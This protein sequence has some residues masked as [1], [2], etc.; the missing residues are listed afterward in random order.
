MT[1]G[2]RVPRHPPSR[3]RG[4]IRFQ[5][6]L[7]TAGVIIGLGIVGIWMSVEVSSRPQFCGSCHIMEPYYES[8][9]GSRHGMV[10]CVECHIPPGVT[11]EFRKKYEALSM[12]ASY[13]TGTYGTNPWTE[14][15]D[16]A[17]LRC[18][19]RRLLT[20]G[21]L[22][23]DVLFDHSAHL[24]GMRRGKTLR[25]TSCHSQIV[26]GSHIA[27]TTSTCVLCHF[28][29]QTSGTGTARCTLC[30]HVPDK[31]IQHESLTFNHADVG[32]LGMDCT[33]CHARPEG[34]DGAVP[35]ERCVT[36]HNEPARLQKYEETE[37]LHR[38]H[39]S[40]HKVDCMDCHLEIQHVGPPRIEQAT[41]ACSICHM[42]GHSPQANLYAGIGGKGVDPMP[43]AMFLAGVRCEGCHLEIPGQTTDTRRASEISC[44]SCHGP[45]YR[46]IF[47]AWKEGVADRTEGLQL[48]MSQTVAALGRS[49][50][51]A[52]ADARF[53]LN[54]VAE[55]RGVHNV[56]YAQALLS[57]SHRDMNVARS[58]RGLPPLSP[59]WGEI[60]QESDCLGCHFGIETSRGSIFGRPFQHA[61]HV[62]DAGL[63]CSSCHRPHEERREDE[64]VRFGAAGCESCHHR[65]VAADCLACHGGIRERT[66]ES[67]LG[68]F[69]H[70]LHLDELELECAD[71][72]EL[73]GDE[74]V[75]LIEETCVNC[76]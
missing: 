59:P 30:H 62:V 41:A 35:R 11:A 68:D 70:I 53:N 31:V 28:K 24:S 40:E 63:E 5:A 74:P 47:L 14:I 73:S 27:V 50:P 15:D 61:R 52:L 42:K 32:R 39:V 34:S 56:E 16:A 49:A 46:R 69:P 6:L 21:E 57:R 48:Q 29:G 1:P 71:C 75:R 33:W 45:K 2:S 65:E 20:G 67:P 36:C 44:M 58:E 23:G 22:F 38:M 64:V 26:Q 9:K 4:A 72:H 12:V 51:P 54:L 17:C 55:G 60:A 18:H 66:V 10:A 37:L 43:N 7:L 76:H 3:A 19:E 25:C 8:W 13:F